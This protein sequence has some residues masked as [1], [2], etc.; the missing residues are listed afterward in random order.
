[1]T[2]FESHSAA[3]T[4]ASGQ[5]LAGDLRPG[6]VVALHG[7]LGAGKT[8]LVKGIARGLGVTQDVTSP[9]FTIVHEYCGGRL[10]LVHVDLYRLDT[11]QQAVAVGIEDY[12]YGKAVTVVEWAEKIM[13]LLPPY[14]I[15]VRLEWRGENERAIVV[16]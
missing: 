9:T 12:F 5:R 2:T 13:P 8:C 1:M 15:H 16:S 4:I 7:E 10:P 6:D 11:L 14:A 3:E